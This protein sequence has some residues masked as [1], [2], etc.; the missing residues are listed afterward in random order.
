VQIVDRWQAG[1]HEHIRL[2]YMYASMLHT[3]Q[4]LR[5]MVSIQGSEARR[6][7][8]HFQQHGYKLGTVECPSMPCS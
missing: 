8:F 1:G 3:V 7:K 2:R 5:H 4:K 6:Q